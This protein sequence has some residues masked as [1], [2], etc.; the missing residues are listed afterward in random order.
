MGCASKMFSVMSSVNVGSQ[1][2][3]ATANDSR[4]PPEC[5]IDGNPDTY[6]VTTGLYPHEVIVSL[7]SPTTIHSVALKTC[8]VRKVAIETSEGI[9]V[10]DFEKV[11]EKE[12]QSQG[13]QIQNEEF[14]LSTPVTAQQIKLVIADG[15][16]HFASVHSLSISGQ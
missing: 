1:V 16:D 14:K 5:I 10:Q 13:G 7:P 11:V 3:L 6:W 4:H 8:N 15:F 12:L 2:T 9:E